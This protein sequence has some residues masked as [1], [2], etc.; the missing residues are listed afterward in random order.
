MPTEES[1]GQCCKDSVWIFRDSA[2][3]HREYVRKGFSSLPRIAVCSKCGN[4]KFV[5]PGIPDEE[6]QRRRKYRQN[7]RNQQNEEK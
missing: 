6:Y 7:K 1:L 2:R 5:D 4:Q 3:R